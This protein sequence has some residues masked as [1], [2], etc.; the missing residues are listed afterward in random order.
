MEKNNLIA[1][2]QEEHRQLVAKLS[3]N[4]GHDPWATGLEAW[5]IMLR[6]ALQE[7]NQTVR[8]A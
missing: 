6:S 8:E 2:I 3:I 1:D 4:N 7:F 5:Q